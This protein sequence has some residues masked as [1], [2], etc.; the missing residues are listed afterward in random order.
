MKWPK[1]GNRQLPDHARTPHTP[2][3]HRSR[4]GDPRQVFTG[5]YRHSV[6]DKGRLAVPSRF[7]AQLDAGL[8]VSR[9]LENCL[10]IHTRASW[11]ALADKVATLPI[12]RRARSSVRAVHLRRR[13]RDDAG[14]TGPRPHPRVPPGHGRPRERGRRGRHAR[15]RRDLGSRSV[16]VVPP[17]PRGSDGARRGHRRSRHLTDG[18][19]AEAAGPTTCASGVRSGSDVRMVEE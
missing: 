17:E 12:D 2:T 7:R 9:W 19:T 3:R 8:V 6:D 10:A 5:E 18:P 4:S 16:G 11:D 14:R 15:P 1:V 13:R